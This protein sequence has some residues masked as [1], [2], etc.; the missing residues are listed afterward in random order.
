MPRQERFKTRYAGVFYVEGKRSG[1][2]VKEKIYYIRYKRGGKTVEEKAGRQYQDDMTPARASGIRAGRIEGKELSNTKRREGVRKKVTIQ[3]LADEYFQ[4]RPDSKTKDI[5][6][7]RYGNY[8]KQPFGNKEPENLVPLDTDRLR[9]KLLKIRSPQTVKHILALLKR[10]INFGADRGI[11]KPLAFK[12]SIPSVDNV[13]TED[14]TE[15]QL[16]RLLDVMATT[17]YQT[18]ANMMKLALFTGMRRGELFKL[19]WS[20]ID[21]QRGFINIREPK[22]GKSQKIPLNNN[23]KAVLQ[24]IAKVDDIYVF[25]ARGGGPRKS[26]SRDVREIKK[27]AGLPPDFRPLHGLRHHFATILASSGKV[28]MYTLQK[29]MTHKSPVMTQRYAHLRDEALKNAAN[30]T[31][32][33]FNSIFDGKKLKAV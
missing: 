29:L 5:D 23:A 14:L 26:V 20:D 11:C 15:E 32:I 10:V 3:S 24:S 31:D 1:R 13:K 8:L 16:H 18:A 33:I 9:V 12:I 21:L 28:D 22:G 6:Q 17:I 4:L 27:E 2:S 30:Q 7:G 25:P 19:E